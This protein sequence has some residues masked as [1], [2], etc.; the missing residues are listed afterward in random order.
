LLPSLLYALAT[1]VVAGLWLRESNAAGA[2]LALLLL[3]SNPQ[4][5]LIASTANVDT[6]ELLFVLASAWCLTVSLKSKRP[7][8]LALLFCGVF[9]GLAMLSRETASFYGLTLALLFLVGFGGRRVD[10][11]IAGIPAVLIV[12]G[13]MAWLYH[14]T[15]DVLYRYRVDVNHDSTINRL[16]EQGSGVPAIHPLLDPLT[17]LVANHNFGL[18]ATLGLGVATWQVVRADST[19]DLRRSSVLMATIAAVWTLI[20]AAWWSKLPLIPRYFLLPSILISLL[21]GIGLGELWQRRRRRTVWLLALL[22]LAANLFGIVA[23]NRNYMFGEHA[24]LETARVETATI[25]TDRNT[26]RRAELLLRLAGV[27]AKVTVAP[28]APGDLLLFNPAH[29]DA[30]IQ[31]G[32]S[33]VEL[34]RIAA[35]QSVLSWIAVHLVPAGVLPTRLIER[36][37]GHPGVVLYRVG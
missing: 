20:A 17:M 4:F 3:A 9:A 35:P 37:R 8:V 31:P 33:W 25:H 12:G 14:A 32:E 22:L 15:G 23:D 34:R 27:E 24:L 13:E 28:A 30:A 7:R 19:L 16:V 11:L 18:L 6:P 36:L 26:L 29:P 1:L 10:Y 21:A 2:L 5:V